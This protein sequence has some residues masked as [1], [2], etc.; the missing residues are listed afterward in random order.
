MPWNPA[1]YK[2]FTAE[3]AAPFDDLAG[4]I[5][6]RPHLDIA[7]LGCGTGELTIKLAERLPNCRVT[8]I[9]S[10]PQMLE[11][12]DKLSTSAVSFRLQDIESFD[13]SWDIIFSNAVLHWLDN[14]EALIPRLFSRLKPGG[15]L[16]VQIPNNNSSP[17]HTGILETAGEEPFISALSGWTRKSPLLCLDR[18]AQLLYEC[19]AVDIILF[20]KVY[21]HMVADSDAISEW[22]AATTLLPY[23]E[24]LPVN[25]HEAFMQSYRAKLKQAWPQSPVL[26]PFRRIILSATKPCTTGQKH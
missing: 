24:R 25:L 14:H 9:D 11:Q 21:L 13:G 15:Q 8:G 12:A 23:F 22:T 5:A 17:S 7:D 4:L 26:F 16:V 10:S 3:R 6:V 2:K 20:E 19:G 18:Y 1:N